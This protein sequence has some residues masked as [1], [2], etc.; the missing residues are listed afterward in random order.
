[1]RILACCLLLVIGGAGCSKEKDGAIRTT[2][3]G[4]ATLPS[5]PAFLDRP[6]VE[7]EKPIEAA[8][9]ADASRVRELQERWRWNRKKEPLVPN[10]PELVGWRHGFNALREY[11]E[12]VIAAYEKGTSDA[13]AARPAALAFLRA[14]V[15]IAVNQGGDTE[16]CAKLS[17]AAVAAGSQDPIVLAFRARN[18]SNNKLIPPAEVIQSLRELQGQWAGKEYP[19]ASIKY[20]AAAWIAS[21]AKHANLPDAPSSM[22]RRLAYGEAA[23]VLAADSASTPAEVLLS[24][25]K[26]TM[27]FDRESAEHREE[28]YR[29]C[30]SEPAIDPWL[31]HM[32]GGEY[33]KKLAWQHR[34]DGWASE[35]TGDGWTKFH[36]YLP[37]SARH[38]RRAWSLH[39]EF[40][41]PAAEMIYVTMSGGDREWTE[42][43]WFHTALIAQADLNLAYQNY[44]FA[45]TPRWG[46]SQ[47]KIAAVA[48]MVIATDRWDL[49]MP[50]KASLALNYLWVDDQVNLPAG[51]NPYSVRLAKRYVESLVAALKRGDVKKEAFGDRLASMAAVLVTAGDYETARSAFEVSPKD[52]A[53]YWTSSLEVPYRYSEGL[54]YAMAG[55]ARD[56]VTELHAF[57][58]KP[59]T[60]APTVEDVEKLQQRLA[61]ARGK[62]GT[63]QARKFFD[64]ASKM[65]DQLHA[66]AA[67]EWVDLTFE[68][69]LEMWMTRCWKSEIVDPRTIR[70]FGDSGGALQLR[71]ITRFA[72]PFIVEAEV[73]PVSA[74]KGSVKTGITIGTGLMKT[75]MQRPAP[76]SIAAGDA[77]WLLTG[78]RALRGLPSAASFEPNPVPR[79][80]FLHIA[81]RRYK[82]ETEYF[83]MHGRVSIDVDPREPMTDYVSF[84]DSGP[85]DVTKEAVFRNLRIRKAPQRVAGDD[86]DPATLAAHRKA[87]EYYPKCPHALLGLA[88]ALVVHNQ[89]NEALEHL[90]TARNVST[91]VIQ[92][93]RVQGAA[94]TAVGK[95]KEADAAFKHELA[96]FPFMVWAR[97]QLAWLLATAPDDSVRNGAGAR[98]QLTGAPPQLRDQARSWSYL[99]TA[100]VVAGELGDFE[101][102]KRLA[103]EADEATTSELSEETVTKV[104]KVLDEGRPYRMPATGEAPPPP[105]FPK[106]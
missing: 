31:V 45:N 33:Y 39:P 104:R 24:F 47:E 2:S 41:E 55:D 78:T 73:K 18:R 87:V 49:L 26:G 88:N 93:H 79:D 43:D 89:P 53:Q 6:L 97:V 59:A 76:Q 42:E 10:G 77:I 25:I 11:R 94:F 44:F 23:K 64:M 91:Q 21:D 56:D 16:T 61:E 74:L 62:D 68:P 50:N 96:S 58:S 15:E 85:E 9:E 71:P 22:M 105:A 82:G 35:V 67:G 92:L 95:F 81:L 34:G 5:R 30:L 65:L 103:A 29:A 4:M 102:A 48:E 72:P 37:K 20:L 32:A 70:L 8:M 36:E 40:A 14:Y 84:G 19:P 80:G 57:L 83:A 17:D 86:V 7:L 98:Q 63:E 99:L 38:Y 46:G 1:M 51:K 52:N 100:A 90:E 13:A 66:Y 60:K 54:A 69:G 3:G 12:R 101:E 75:R 28:L 27:E 106:K